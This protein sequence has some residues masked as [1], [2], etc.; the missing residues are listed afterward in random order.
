MSYKDCIKKISGD[1]KGDIFVFALSTCGW[2][3][4]TKELLNKLKVEYC[5]V[6]VDLLDL[7]QREEVKKEFDK[8]KTDFSF[9]KV[10]INNKIISGF[11]PE[12]IKKAIK[13]KAENK[14]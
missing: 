1:K 12:E 7:K 14:K 5:Y 3:A 10:R 2:C 4:K 11:Q 8:Y 9:P 13:D 6:D